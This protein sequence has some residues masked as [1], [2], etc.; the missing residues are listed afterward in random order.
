MPPAVEHQDPAHPAV[1]PDPV[2]GQG[3]GQGQD[4]GPPVGVMGV[5]DVAVLGQVEVAPVEA[6]I[7]QVQPI[8]VSSHHNGC[9]HWNIPGPS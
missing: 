4:Q 6:A 8:K 1:A 7:G 9:L 5:H 3:P 2:D